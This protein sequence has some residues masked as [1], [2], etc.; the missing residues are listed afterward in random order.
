M[1][2]RD[3]KNKSRQLYNYLPRISYRKVERVREQKEVKTDLKK[4]ETYKY[5]H[6]KSL[7]S[8][9][10]TDAIYLRFCSLRLSKV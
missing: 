4:R 8:D 3:C 1:R 6:K 10:Q 5:K 2:E 9:T 7:I